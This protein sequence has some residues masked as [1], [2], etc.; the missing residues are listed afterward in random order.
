M[1][2]TTQ[3]C[4]KSF[5]KPLLVSLLVIALAGCSRCKKKD[6]PPVDPNMETLDADE[7]F[8]SFF[9]RF[10]TDTSFQFSRIHFPIPV[11]GHPMDFGD[12]GLEVADTIVVVDSSYTEDYEYIPLNDSITPDGEGFASQI[13]AEDSTAKVKYVNADSS[14]NLTLYFYKNSGR[15][16][17]EK[18][19]DLSY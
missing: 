14:F 17:L 9:N 2:S 3:T 8:D 4:S 13:M 16:F 19:V 5:V 6:E 10:K 18:V 7:S 1:L 11:W 12:D 15:W